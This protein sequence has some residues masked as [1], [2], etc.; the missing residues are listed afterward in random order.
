MSR[1]NA[2]EAVYAFVCFKSP[3]D[4]SKAKAELNNKQYM[5]KQL[6]INHYE[7]KEMRSILQ[8]EMRDKQDYQNYQ[9]ANINPITNIADV[10]GK[11]EMLQVLQ[12]VL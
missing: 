2:A 7:I 12:Q 6:Y 8:E 11:P 9:K 3:E 10:I 5:G 1:E 4:A